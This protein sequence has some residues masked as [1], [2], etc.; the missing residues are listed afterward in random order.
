MSEV[1]LLHS[2]LG[3]R[4]GVLSWAEWLR[5]EGH[6]V[7]VPDLYGGEVFDSY[8]EGDAFVQNFGGYPELLRRTAN[9]VQHLP[10]DL[11]YAGFSNGA[12]G[13]A[14]LAATRP[15]ARAAL[16]MHGALPLAVLEQVVG[17]PVGW[18]ASVPVQLHYGRDDPFRQESSVQAFSGDVLHSDATFE[19]FE[20]PVGGHLFADQSLTD[21]YDESAADQMWDRVLK[22]LARTDEAG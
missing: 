12:G 18:P 2:V 1:V 8:Q 22:F 15:G 16:L 10:S 7:H 17:A 11:V 6:S 21:E 14:Y 9:A 13:A 5:A 4:P 19:Y 20:Y 3:L